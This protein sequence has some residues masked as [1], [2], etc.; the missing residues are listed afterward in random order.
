MRRQ[1]HELVVDMVE[2]GIP[3]EL[4]KR[5]FER[6]YLLQVVAAHDGNHSAAARSLGIHRNTLSKKLEPM[7]APLRYPE[8]AC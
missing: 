5:E 7:L 8:A 4:A 6:A 1:L 2:K 3:L